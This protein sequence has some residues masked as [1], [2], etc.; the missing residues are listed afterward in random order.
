MAMELL[1][2]KSWIFSHYLRDIWLRQNVSASYIHFLRFY[3]SFLS[4]KIASF[5]DYFSECFLVT[6][7]GRVKN[8]TKL[9]FQNFLNGFIFDVI[10]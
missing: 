1:F 8:Y 7:V 10:P 4:L 3:V 9:Y 5:K 2:R 6:R